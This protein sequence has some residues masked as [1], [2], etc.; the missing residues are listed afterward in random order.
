M[1]H[2][3]LDLGMQPIAN[4]FLP[5]IPEKEN[6]F[7]F[8]L[9]VSYDD[10]T[11]LV[12]L[13]DFVPPD[14]MFNENYVYHSSMSKTMRDHFSSA[15]D[16]LKN[17]LN[18]ETVL[19]IGSNDGVFIRNFDSSKTIAIEPCGNFADLTNK[20]GYLTHCDFWSKEIVEK[21]L[22]TGQKDLIFSANCVCHIQDL[23]DAFSAVEKVL[24]KKGAFV[25]EDPSLYRMIKRGS[26]DQLYDEH[27]HVFSVTALSNVLERNNMEIFRVESLDVHGGSNRIFACRI[28]ERSIDESVSYHI[29]MEK[30]A[31]LDRLETYVN[32]GKQIETSKK[33]L[34]NLLKELKRK[35]S[36]IISYG[37]TSKSTTVFNYCGI[38]GSTID[39]IVDTTPSKQNKF[40]PGVHIPVIPP[41]EGMTE[42]VDYAFLG[43]WNFENEITAKEKDFLRRG[44]FI[45]HVPFVRIIEAKDN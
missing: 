27:A 12:S 36:K 23:D 25:F 35:G 37:A 6:E 18:P 40:S 38:N 43:A 22:E 26:Y 19:E 28:G 45:T 41:E 11:S 4:N 16:H 33:Q 21:V 31:G 10:E 39:Y 42:D 9:T 5:E 29:S 20:M 14:L 3:F 24:S 8:H 13:D 1:K 30:E 15:A 44:R 2:R 17:I 32:F 7:K 34:T